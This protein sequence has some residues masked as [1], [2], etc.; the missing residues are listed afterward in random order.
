MT[1]ADSERLK[2]R[3]RDRADYRVVS[4]LLQDALLPVRD[5]AQLPREKRFV[6]LAN[7]FRWEIGASLSDLPDQPRPEPPPNAH[8]GACGGDASFEDATFYERVQ[9]G[10]AFDRVTQVH[11]RGFRR[12]DAGTVLNLL[13]LLPDPAGVTLQ[14]AGG[15]ALRLQGKRLVC[16]LEDLGEPWPTRWRPRHAPSAAGEPG[17]ASAA[18]PSEDP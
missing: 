5:M 16:H 6:L 9:C 11:Y 8:S 17:A 2:L 14:C 13:A 7:R 18:S 1:G 12:D 10:I 15:A 3:A 4:A